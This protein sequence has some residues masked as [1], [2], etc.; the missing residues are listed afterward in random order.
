MS[1][2]DK[3]EDKKPLNL[4]ASDEDIKGKS[5]GKRK[6]IPRVQDLNRDVRIA[7]DEKSAISLDKEVTDLF[8]EHGFA[9]RWVR[10]TLSGDYDYQNINKKK[11]RGYSFVHEDEV[12]EHLIAMLGDTRKVT[13]SPDEIITNGD[14]AL[15]KVPIKYNEEW[16][17]KRDKLN[18]RNEEALD[19]RL[20]KAISK[21]ELINESGTETSFGNPNNANIIEKDK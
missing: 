9:L 7:F 6:R 14:L 10:L 13:G 15:M 18:A 5:T 19:A 20:G 17:D 21:K 12:P 11:K 8:H 3:K 4:S 2:K 1:T 16:Q